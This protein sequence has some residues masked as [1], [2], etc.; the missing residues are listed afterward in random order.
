MNGLQPSQRYVSECHVLCAAAL[1]HAMVELVQVFEAETGATLSI[2]FDA[3]PAIAQR[4]ANGEAFDIT[5]INPHLI[6]DLVGLVDPSTKVAFGQ[7]PLG[8][9]ARRGHRNIDASTV[10]AFESILLGAQSIGYGSEGTSGKRLLAILHRM[11]LTDKVR[12]KLVPLPAGYAGQ[13][14]A[15]GEV[16]LCI[17]PIS[18][19]IAASP[20]AVVAA[21]LPS[22]LDIQIEFAAAVSE[23]AGKRTLS[24]A[25]VAFLVAPRINSLIT[26]KGYRAPNNGLN[27]RRQQFTSL[28]LRISRWLPTCFIGSDLLLACRGHHNRINAPSRLESTGRAKNSTIHT[29][30]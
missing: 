23:T 14:V 9:G 16:E 24:A 4:I 29:H 30:A 3:N 15:A 18:T 10:S 19:I 7:S 25:F 2:S 20:E 11:H 21:T 5:V 12:H 27:D 6:D 28:R 1:R 8:L 17:V 13:A 26:A 22:E